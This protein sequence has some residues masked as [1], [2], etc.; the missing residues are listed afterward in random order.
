MMFL[1]SF[2]DDLVRLRLPVTAGAVLATV[3]ALVEPFGIAL[4]GD[5][6]AK[7][8]TALVAVGVIAQYVQSKLSGRE[9]RP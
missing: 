4:G 9:P 8:T 2:L 5:T 6:T 7:V 1:R 3:L